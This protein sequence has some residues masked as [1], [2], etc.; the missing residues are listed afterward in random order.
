[1]DLVDVFGNIPYTDAFGTNTRPV[2][3]KDNAVYIALQS[4]LDIAIKYMGRKK[5]S[6]FNTLDKVNA[7]SQALWIKFANTLKLKMLIHQSE[8]IGFDATA[9]ISNILSNGG[10]FLGA[11]ENIDVNPGY[12]N[13]TNK[14][15]PFYAN[16]GL[17]PTGNENNEITR[18]NNYFIGLMTTADPRLVRLF[19]RVSGNVV[20][21]DYGT[22]DNPPGS[23]TSNIGEGLATSA[24][25]SQWIQTSFESMFLEAEA[26]LRGWLP[27][28]DAAAKAK[29]E[30]AIAESF[31][32]LGIPS[33]G[34]GYIASSSLANWTNAGTTVQA[35]AKF[36]AV[37]KYFAN[38]GINPLESWCDLR[39]LNMLPAGYISKNTQ[40]IS[41]TVP[42]RLKYPQSEYNYNAAN[43]NA[44]GS[45]NQF[46]SK[47]FWIP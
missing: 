20:G 26:I 17:S 36:I 46:S 34:A 6:S 31:S 14:Q 27:G 42:L 8:L 40:R 23:A 45:I 10:G 3:D 1:M 41:N 12:V 15:S 30:S 13:E 5:L 47:I 4:S 29:F 43:V 19:R 24:T 37:Q 32:F 25:Q 33:S 16:Y 18:A 28:G 11:G 2:Y 39:R 35:K 9:E 21:N 22:L 38:A 44:Q 7:G